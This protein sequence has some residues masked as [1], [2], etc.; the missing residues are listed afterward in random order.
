MA[1]KENRKNDKNNQKGI[2]G[3]RQRE[4]QQPKQGAKGKEKGDTNVTTE[5]KNDNEFESKGNVNG[6]NDNPNKPVLA[7]MTAD[8]AKL[9]DW[10]TNNGIPTDW[11]KDFDSFENMANIYPDSE[12]GRNEFYKD[13][14]IKGGK[15]KNLAERLFKELEKYRKKSNGM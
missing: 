5:K 15:Q 7:S 6:D 12:T 3:Q 10:A 11:V 14:S 1:S 2:V 9:V 8:K 4:Q 13:Y